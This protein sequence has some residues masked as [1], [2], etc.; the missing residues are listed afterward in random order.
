MKIYK[1]E[2]VLCLNRSLIGQHSINFNSLSLFYSVYIN[3]YIYIYIYIYIESSCYV[4][5]WA[6]K[7]QCT[8]LRQ[9]IINMYLHTL[10]RIIC[11]SITNALLPD[12]CMFERC[13]QTYRCIHMLTGAC[14]HTCM[15]AS[16]HRHTHTHT[17][18][19]RERERER[20]CHVWFYNH[21]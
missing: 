4:K 15:H 14:L 9:H 8:I 18:R 12:F 5:V 21:L 17:E 3:I 6:E 2:N 16:V 1:A 19:E 11:T 10:E 7:F 20:G 13:L